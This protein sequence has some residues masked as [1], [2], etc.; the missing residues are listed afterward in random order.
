MI[1]AKLCGTAQK[2]PRKTLTPLLVILLLIISTR[3]RDS[4]SRNCIYYYDCRRSSLYPL[5]KFT[6]DEESLSA[7]GKRFRSRLTV[8][9]IQW[10]PWWHS[11]K[12]DLVCGVIGVTWG[13]E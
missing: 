13:G 12:N 1:A 11:R 10:R 6:F 5:Y 3:S 8:Y 4:F 2:G 7:V 9:M